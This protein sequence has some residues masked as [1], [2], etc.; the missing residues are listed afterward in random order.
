MIFNEKIKQDIKNRSSLTFE[1]SKDIA[2]LASFICEKTGR[3]IGI[4]TLKRLFGLLSDGRNT[5]QY[6]LNT[7]ALYL[8][9]NTWEEYISKNTLDSVWNYRDNAIFIKNLKIGSKVHV[10]YI[11]RDVLMIVVEYKKENALQVASSK[12]SSLQKGDIL[13]IYKLKIGE[14]I[15]AEQVIRGDS[16]GNYKTK[17]EVSYVEIVPPD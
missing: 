10:K 16:L 2:T 14:I 3:T 7:I 12:N 15:E 17:G 9:Y 4:T 13:I 1:K 5:Y 11:D 8:G 6:T